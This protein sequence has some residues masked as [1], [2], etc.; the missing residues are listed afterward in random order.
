MGKDWVIFLFDVTAG[1]SLADYTYSFKMSGLENPERESI[2]CFN[3]WSSRFVQKT[4][5]FGVNM[6]KNKVRK[7]RFRNLVTV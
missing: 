6:K 4:T 1:N 5:N 2:R 7:F 3:A